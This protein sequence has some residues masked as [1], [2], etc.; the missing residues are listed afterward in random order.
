MNDDV[1]LGASCTLGSVRPDPLLCKTERRRS[2][3]AARA[4]IVCGSDSDLK[5]P[6]TID[7]QKDTI[8]MCSQPG[9]LNA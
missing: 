6:P 2:M 7:S 5:M 8:R 3:H 4:D 9:V 1:M